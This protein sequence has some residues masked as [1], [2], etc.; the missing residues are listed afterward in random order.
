MQGMPRKKTALVKTSAKNAGVKQLVREAIREERR[1]SSLG[2]GLDKQQLR[3]LLLQ[4]M[5]DPVAGRPGP[6]QV[7]SP[8]ESEQQMKEEMARMQK[9]LDW[10]LGENNRLAARVTE[11]EAEIL[12]VKPQLDSQQQ[13]RIAT[14]EAELA[15]LKS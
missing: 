7:L 8:F 1:R 11:L 6:V 3:D 5:P 9:S 4:L 13:E 2:P 15:K 14:L 12:T 10:T